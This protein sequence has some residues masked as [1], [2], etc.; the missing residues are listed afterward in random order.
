MIENKRDRTSSTEIKSFELEYSKRAAIALFRYAYDSMLNQHQHP[1][2]IECEV[3][4]TS[5]IP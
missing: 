4:I 2:R 3:V 5:L 1:S